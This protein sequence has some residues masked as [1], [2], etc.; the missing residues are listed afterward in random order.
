[1]T[2]TVRVSFAA[3][4]APRKSSAPANPLA[5]RDQERRRALDM[6]DPLEV[7][8]NKRRTISRAEN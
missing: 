4:W 3:P 7:F 6:T 8:R 1:V 5:A 2:R